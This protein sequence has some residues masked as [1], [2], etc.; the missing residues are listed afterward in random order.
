VTLGGRGGGSS[1]YEEGDFP[2]STH[3]FDLGAVDAWD[4]EKPGSKFAVI[5]AYARIGSQ[6]GGTLDI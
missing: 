3:F 6:V 1:I 5:P 2:W 4:G